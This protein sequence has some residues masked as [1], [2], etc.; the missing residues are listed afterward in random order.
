MSTPLTRLL[1][2]VILSSCLGAHTV[3]VAAQAPSTGSVTSAQRLQ[4]QA[5]SLKNGQKVRVH[6]VEGG[7]VRGRVLGATE[8]G[9][10]I[11][12]TPSDEPQ[13]I[14]YDNI[15]SLTSGMQTWV[16]LAIGVGAAGALVAAIAH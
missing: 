6:L 14:A 13:L 16:K 10:T 15:R 4:T 7:V 12:P 8:Q 11:Q 2:V 5:Q 3:S 9:L 1:S